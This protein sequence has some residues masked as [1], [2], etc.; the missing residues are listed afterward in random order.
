MKKMLSKIGTTIDIIADKVYSGIDVTGNKLMLEEKR[1]NV[2]EDMSSLG[3]VLGVVAKGTGKAVYNGITDTIKGTTEALIDMHFLTNR[4][5]NGSRHKPGEVSTV[6][7]LSYAGAMVAYTGVT[8]AAG[9]AA[10]PAI[11]ALLALFTATNFLD[12]G[13]QGARAY[14]KM[15]LEEAKNNRYR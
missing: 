11:L 13:I 5:V 1:S 9:M 10:I 8:I 3:E 14:K 12:M 7:D 15:Q 2:Y 6:R 4:F